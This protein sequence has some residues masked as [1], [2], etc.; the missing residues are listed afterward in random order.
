MMKCRINSRV[1]RAAW[2][3]NA[4]LK[5]ESALGRVQVTMAKAVAI[6]QSRHFPNPRPNVVSMAYSLAAKL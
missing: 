6:E 2:V 4:Q 1:I 5:T 3:I